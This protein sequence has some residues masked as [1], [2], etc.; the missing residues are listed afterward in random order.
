MSEDQ[1]LQALLDKI[2][3]EGVVKAETKAA[4]I[5]AAAEARAARI[6][7]DAEQSAREFRERAE[8][9]AAAFAERA[10]ESV[11]QVARDVVLSVSKG[12]TE[13]LEGLLLSEGRVALS[14]PGRLVAL[15]E[16]AVSSYLSGGISELEVVVGE[17]AAESVEALRQGFAAR[18]VEGVSVTLDKSTGAG[19]RV[20][21]DGGRVEHDFTAAAITGAIASRLRPQLAGLLQAG[22][23]G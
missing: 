22:D 1:H 4:E 9:D 19:F 2:H 5:V 18:A 21:L 16:S 6:V 12:V 13:Q 23:K 15:V 17:S 3:S 14:E 11:R 20:R 8:R 10:S 7:A